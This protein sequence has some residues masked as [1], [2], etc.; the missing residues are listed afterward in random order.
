M[1]QHAN[2]DAT[3]RAAVKDWVREAVQRLPERAE[4]ESLHAHNI[5]QQ[6]AWMAEM[7][8]E[9]LATAHWPKAYGGADL[10]LR[11]RAALVEEYVRAG[12]PS[13]TL[14]V[15]SHNHIPATLI[16][17]GTDW[18][19]E[20]YLPAAAQGEIWCQGFSEPGA[21]SDLASLRTRARRE[22]DDYIIN[23]QKIW[24]SYSMYA[25]RAILLAR[26]DPDAPKHAGI[27]YFLLDLSAPGVE[28]RPIRQA[29]GHAKFAEIFLTDVRVPLRDRVGEEGDGWKIAQSTLA[30]ERGL[31]WIDTIERAH[32]RL[33]TLRA[34]AVAG[35]DWARDVELSRQFADLWVVVQGLRQIMR[36]ML[37]DETSAKAKDLVSTAALKVLCSE[38]RRDLGTFLIQIGSTD[39]YLVEEDADDILGGA[40]FVRMSQYSSFFGG[41]T[42]EIMRNIIAERG[43]GMPRQ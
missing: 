18:Q 27:S 37:Y 43:L 12:A 2:D 20:T 14:Y 38:M 10:P 7:N 9:G 25:S 11:N 39:R 8:R 19:K 28:V 16:P 24:S 17:W 13:P 22:G 1:L 35:G 41:G 31:F 21:G 23:G 32:M 29:N 40:M 5:R 30:S 26:T 33:K 36:E 6:K 34:E 4:G 15:I 3:F 42:N